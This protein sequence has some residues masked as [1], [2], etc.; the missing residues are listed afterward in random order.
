MSQL[1]ETMRPRTTKRRNGF[2]IIEFIISTFVV[3]VALLVSMVVAQEMS[4]QMRS[5]HHR[6][7][8]QDNARVAIEEISR[9]LRG[10]GSQTDQSRGQSRFLYGG[11]FT[12]AFNANL[13]PVDDADGLGLPM[14]VDVDLADASVPLSGGQS[15]TPLRTFVTGAETIVLT[16]DSTRDGTLSSSDASDDEEEASENPRD[17]VLKSYVYGSEHCRGDGPRRPARPCRRHAWRIAG[18]P[19]PVL[20]RRRQ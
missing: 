9:L 13:T 10:A 17:Y 7:G 5:E 16:L 3:A 8:S 20:A 1:K 14:A 15:Y 19:V 6:I 11:P 4:K 12:I 18:T 2:T